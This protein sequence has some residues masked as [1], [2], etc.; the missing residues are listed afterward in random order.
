MPPLSTEDAREAVSILT[1]R[2]TKVKNAMQNEKPEFDHLYHL[3]VEK[4]RKFYHRLKGCAEVPTSKVHR[5]YTDKKYCEFFCKDK[6]PDEEFISR[7]LTAIFHE[8]TSAENMTTLSELFD[9]SKQDVL[10]NPLEHRIMIKS[11]NPEIIEKRK[12]LILPNQNRTVDPS[13]ILMAR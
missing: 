11:R 13:L 12:T 3:T 8:G 6:M 10:L 7:Y 2:M 9:Y 1:N 5:L 4:I